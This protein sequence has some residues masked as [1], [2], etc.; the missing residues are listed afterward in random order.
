MKVMLSYVHYNL[1]RDTN[2]YSDP[3]RDMRVLP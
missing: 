2:I 3:N 1:N